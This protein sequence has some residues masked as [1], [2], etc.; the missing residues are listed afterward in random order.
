MALISLRSPSGQSGMSLMSEESF[1]VWDKAHRRCLV[2]K[3]NHI[4]LLLNFVAL[5]HLT[6]QPKKYSLPCMPFLHLSFNNKKALCLIQFLRDGRVKNTV[7]C[8]ELA[9]SQPF[10]TLALLNKEVMSQ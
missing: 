9:A 5:T 8:A 3:G 1:S 2:R 6:N 4:C 7:L 10:A